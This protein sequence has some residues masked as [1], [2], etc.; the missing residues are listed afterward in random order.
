MSNDTQIQKIT[1]CACIIHDGKVFVARRALDKPFL[2]GVYE[3]PGGHIEFGESVEEW[4]AREIKEELH[5]DV[6]IEKPFYAFT[7]VNTSGTKHTIEVVYFATM[8]DPSQPI[9]TNPEDH[10]SYQRATLEQAQLLFQDNPKENIAIQKWFE[11][12]NHT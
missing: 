6:R 7:Y 5:I 2:P 10:E 8:I 9:Q 11:C 1:A 4:L 3:L 12:F